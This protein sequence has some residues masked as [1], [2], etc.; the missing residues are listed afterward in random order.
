MD[1]EK[2]HWQEPGTAWKGVGIYHVTLVVPSREALLGRLV[3]PDNDP[4]KAYVERTQLGEEIVNEIYN[5]GKIHPEIRILQFCLMPDH[6]HFI[7]HVTRQMKMSVRGA[8]RGFWQGAKRIG[9]AYTLSVV[10]ELNSGSINKVGMAELNSESIN[11]VG[12]AELNSESIDKVDED[13]LHHAFPIFT[14]QPFVRPLSRKGQLQTMYSYI[15]MNP[16]RLAT[17]KLKP[18]FFYVQRDIEIGGRRYRGVG[19]AAILTA[20]QYMP[21]HVRWTMVDEAKHGDDKRLRDYMNSCVLAA[22]EGAV[23]VSPF[24]S[25]DEKRIQAKLLEE[26]LHFICIADNGFGE[27]YKPA[28]GLFDA[29][30]AGRVMILSPWEYDPKKRHVTREE[31]VAMNK[32]AEEICEGVS[33]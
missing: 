14:E 22:R 8:L 4:A 33:G 19:N 32:M 25:P 21:V 16:Q 11:K 26:R 27:Y 20:E 3:I 31:C 13:A 9:R 30:A 29:V 7:I 6:L 15:R 12:M 18:G 23:M 17:R 2:W 28:D 24:I 10:P 1:N 5:L